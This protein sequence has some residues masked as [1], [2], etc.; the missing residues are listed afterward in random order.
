MRGPNRRER[1][2]DPPA[3]QRRSAPCRPVCW[4][5]PYCF[6]S[7]WDWV[8]V[9][10]GLGWSAWHF[11]DE[12]IDRAR[13][14]LARYQRLVAT[15]P[16][17]R[18]ELEAVNNNQDFKAFYFAAQTPALAGAT[19]QQNVQDIVKAAGSRLVS[20]QIL[21]ATPNEQPPTVR[22][23]I[24]LQGSTD[25]LFEVLYQL[26]Q[27]R[28][29]LFVDQVSIR[30][31][32]QP[33]RPVAP[34]RNRQA[35]RPPSRPDDRGSD[36][37]PRHLR[38]RPGWAHDQGAAGRTGPGSRRPALLAVDRLAPAAPRAGRRPIAGGRPGDRL[39][40]SL[41]PGSRPP[42]TARSMPRSRIVRCFGPTGARQ[43]QEPT[44][45]VEAPTAVES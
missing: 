10:P 3:T 27:S 43:A 32:A 14:Q 17:L 38:L 25:Q 19:L 44:D 29:F 39:A 45:A 8:W 16:S 9:S 31:M 13:D 35:R 4:P 15:L 20:T 40:R 33:E 2:R 11:R 30:S 28:P 41:W 23:R 1:T 26:E 24:Q 42:K 6:W 5:G 22:V 37:A 21:P 18:A 12:D 36:R 34:D 7:P